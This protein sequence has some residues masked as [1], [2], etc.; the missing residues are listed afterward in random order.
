[1]QISI[2]AT[3][4]IINCR[5]DKIHSKLN[6]SS[7]ILNGIN[8]KVLIKRIHIIVR[9]QICQYLYTYFRTILPL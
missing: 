3:Y 6:V 9:I 8:K 5:D 1:M 2:T 4:Y 7:G